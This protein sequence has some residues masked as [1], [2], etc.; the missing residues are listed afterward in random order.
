MSEGLQGSKLNKTSATRQSRRRVPPRTVRRL[1]LWA[2]ALYF[3]PLFGL[4]AFQRQLVFNTRHS[5]QTTE[6]M[7]TSGAALP[8][9]AHE[10]TL[11]TA[12][13]DT[14]V[15]LYGCAQ[16]ADG[17]PDPGS[18][19]RPTLLFFYGKGSSVA[20]GRRL[21][22]SLRR[23]DVNVLMPDYVGF[24]QSGGQESEANCYATAE[25]AYRYLRARPD[26]DQKSIV[27]AGFSLGSCVAVDL[28]ARELP[29]GRPV[30]GLAV[31]AAYT[32]LADEA[33][34][35]YPIYPA[36]LLRLLLRSP[37]ASESKMPRVTC[38]VL[39]VHS[40]ADRLIPYWMADKLAAASGGP[41]TR[42][43]ITRA[44][45]SDYFR[46]EGLAVFGALGRF[47]LKVT[48]HETKQKPERRAAANRIRAARALPQAPR[49]RPALP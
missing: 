12:P 30:A 37:F 39:L 26:V 43:T 22:Q 49:A 27:I 24:G 16:R 32:S 21:F 45:H 5:R 25:A 3:V 46:V 19:R 20:G 36:F 34:R 42:L 31:F 2:A 1:L 48:P 4:A 9:G 35:Q 8:A 17:R 13:G 33:H 6:A 29:V 15:A 14:V 10:L 47:I 23:L 44:D 38:P 11:R 41:V 18:A 40:R 28:A 7:R